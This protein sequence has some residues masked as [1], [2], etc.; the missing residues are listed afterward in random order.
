V[1]LVGPCASSNCIPRS[2]TAR[3]CGSP[4]ARPEELGRALAVARRRG[5]S[6]AEAAAA[7]Q[8]RTPEGP[9]VAHAATGSCSR[10]PARSTWPTRC[11]RTTPEAC[12]GG[13][14]WSPRRHARARQPRP[15]DA[16]DT[17]H[18][19]MTGAWTPTFEE[20]DADDL[21]VIGEIPA[22]LDGVYPAQHRKPRARAD[23]ALPPVRRRRDD[24]RHGVPGRRGQLPQPLRPH[25]G[26]RGGGGGRRG[27]VGGL[28]EHPRQSKRPGW[29]AQGR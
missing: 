17:D 29:G 3:R 24:P 14:A 6:V 11:A 22:D 26:L 27:A 13:A 21:S 23:R 8:V 12:A 9:V 10:T 7:V 4:G 28:A 1:I 25:Q 18:P 2:T 20:W 16:R 19:Y 5:P 15:L